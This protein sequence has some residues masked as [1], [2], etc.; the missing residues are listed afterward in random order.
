MQLLLW[1][2][3]L[4]VLWVAIAVGMSAHMLLALVEPGTVE[5]LI[6]GR[7]DDAEITTGLVVFAGLFWV[8]PLMMAFLGFVLRD[9]ANRFTNAGVGFVITVMWAWDL[10]ASVSEGFSGLTLVLAG[11]FAAGLSILWHAWRWPEAQDEHPLTEE[12]TLASARTP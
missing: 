12:M 2:V 8:V 10:I 4:S 11:M 7:M 3:R 9:P 6:E 5:E 1:K